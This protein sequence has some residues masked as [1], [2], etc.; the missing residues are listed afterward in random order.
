[1]F[2]DR[3]SKFLREKFYYGEC[4]HTIKGIILMKNI[5]I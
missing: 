5:I 4:Q 1:M 2:E 3:N